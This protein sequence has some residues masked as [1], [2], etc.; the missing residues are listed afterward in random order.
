MMDDG[1]TQ[2]EASVKLNE[3]VR[4]VL[5]NRKGGSMTLKLT[6][7]PGPAGSVSTTADISLTLPKVAPDETLFFVDDAF[8]LTKQDPK[9]KK[10]NF[11]EVERP[12]SEVKEVAGAQAP[13]KTA[14]G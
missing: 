1:N 11:A 12:A 14:V 3:L 13:A 2:H 5:L 6:V 8:C 4:S 10:F 7:K 9:Q